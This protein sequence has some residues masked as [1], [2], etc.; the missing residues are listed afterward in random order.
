MQILKLFNELD[1]VF[2]KR[3]IYLIFLMLIAGFLEMIGVGLILPLLTLL[4]GISETSSNNY[5][6]LIT[7]REDLNLN[8]DELIIYLI[9]VICTLYVIKNFYLGIIYYLQVKFIKDFQIKLGKKLLSAYLSMPLSY[10]S[11]KNSSIFIRNLSFD[12]VLL[13][14]SI[15]SYAILVL[16]G[17]IILLIVTLLLIT[18]PK[19]TLIIIFCFTI[20]I[21]I[22]YYFTDKR[23]KKWGESRQYYESEK[24]KH[25]KQSIEFVREIKIYNIKD[26]FLKLFNN[27]NLNFSESFKRHHFL[28][29]IAKLWLETLTV[30]LIVVLLFF[31]ITKSSAIE[32]IPIIGLFAA[33]AFRLLPSMNR[34][35]NSLNQLKFVKSIEKIFLHDLVSYNELL[36]K[37]IDEKSD[38]SFKKNITFDN[39]TFG[40]SKEK[41]IFNNLN[42]Q[43]K[44]GSKIGIF[45]I[46]GKGKST[47]FDL[48]AGILIP[49]KGKILIDGKDLKN[50]IN[51]WQSILGYTHQNT[52][53]LDDTIENN[54]AIGDDAL[55]TD[56]LKKVIKIANLE[57]FISEL[58]EG[59]KS[60]I[61]EG[62][63]NISGGQKQR[64]GIA[65][66]LYKNPEVLIFDEAFNSL[67][68]NS[69]EKIL[70]NLNTLYKDKTILFISHDLS[71]KDHC[72]QI[73]DLNNF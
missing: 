25:L 67:D 43:I 50:Y 72:D 21:S 31:T 11:N 19:F 62:G 32:S 23:I 5:Y 59:I 9:V 13:A 6:F 45:G 29:A 1:S 49:Q 33:A 52:I 65:R 24:I 16:E 7:L 63:N 42:L 26:F 30:L 66:T 39:V 27:S 44:K 64:I 71:L 15:S 2:K 36:K 57:D 20:V 60:R 18:L 4:T 48:L 61:L 37:K 28:Q 68:K 10:F 56:R 8:E 55:D 70:S 35:V 3:T 58:K 14:N 47:L 41:I 22:Y 38:L 40:Y 53:I 46:S 54:I 51:S 69:T 12:L 73:I 34:I 17:S